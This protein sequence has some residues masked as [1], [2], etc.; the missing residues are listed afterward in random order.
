MSAGFAT[1]VLPHPVPETRLT[2][3]HGEKEVWPYERFRY[4]IKK[5]IC[6]DFGEQWLLF[7]VFK[8]TVLGILLV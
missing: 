8:V 6:F 3:I 1:V 4:A 5:R 7:I 2:K